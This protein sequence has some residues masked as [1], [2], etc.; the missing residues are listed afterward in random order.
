MIV[1]TNRF[2]PE[3]NALLR[4]GVPA[5]WQHLPLTAGFEAERSIRVE[6]INPG[7]VGQALGEGDV[8][9]ALLSVLE[10][11]ELPAGR[12]LPA[13]C[14][15][16]GPM[17]QTV[18]VRSR[19][20]GKDLCCI[21]CRAGLAARALLATV[22]LQEQLG[23]PLGLDCFQG[24]GDGQVEA[25]LLSP[26]EPT[27]DEQ[28]WPIGWNIDRLWWEQTALPGVLWFWAARPGRADTPEITARLRAGRCSNGGQLRKAIMRETSRADL[29][30]E[31]MAT[32]CGGTGLDWTAAH[33]E[34]LA[35]LLARAELAGLIRAEPD[36]SV[37]GDEYC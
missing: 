29:S 7:H 26:I 33:T 27:A 16:T 14:I 34:G 31:A 3:R 28:A 4:V 37:V 35:E 24:P 1:R 10:L 13:G 36:W 2:V 20:A 8:D 18:R 17:S 15:A 6:P 30:D 12:I 5:G 21:H 9:V 22:T 11:S 32:I 25:L 19:R 23:H